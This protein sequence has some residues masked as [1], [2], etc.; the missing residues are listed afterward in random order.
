MAHS[1]KFY[2]DIS[3][4]TPIVSALQFLQEIS[5]PSALDKVVY[6]GSRSAGKVCR[7]LSA[8]GADPVLLSL[9]GPRA[10][11]VKLALSSA[12][13]DSAVGGADLDLGFQVSSG[14]ANAVP[15]HVRVLD[16]GHVGGRFP[17]AVTTNELVEVAP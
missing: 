9:S 3:L 6:F 12:G 11:D 16:S 4:T 15:V 7:A 13:L 1:F 14:V 10:A 2:S 8:P 17:V 5:A